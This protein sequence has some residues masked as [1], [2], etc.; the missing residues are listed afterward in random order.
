MA[1][2]KKKTEA[3]KAAAARTKSASS[4]KKKQQEKTTDSLMGQIPVRFISSAVCFILFVLFL[5]IYLRGKW[6]PLYRQEHK[7]PQRT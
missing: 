6:N 7:I 5:I 3:E 1:D 2:K 4:A